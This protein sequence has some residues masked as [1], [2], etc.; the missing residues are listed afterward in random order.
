MLP[1]ALQEAL[2][3]GRAVQGQEGPLLPGQYLVVDR[4]GVQ[5]VFGVTREIAHSQGSVCVLVGTLNTVGS[6]FVGRR[7]GPRQFWF[8][9]A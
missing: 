5:A 8:H 3:Q 4:P 9:S 2:G 1:G 7:N 6:A